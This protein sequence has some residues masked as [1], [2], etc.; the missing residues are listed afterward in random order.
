LFTLVSLLFNGISSGD[1]ILN[2]ELNGQVDPLVE[3]GYSHGVSLNSFF[4]VSFN[5]F[6]QES[7]FL[8]GSE[9][10]G[11]GSSEFVFLHLLEEGFIIEEFTD[12]FETEL[13]GVTLTDFFT[14]VSEDVAKSLEDTRALDHV[15]RSE[16][17]DGV[18][19][20]FWTD[21]VILLVLLF[22]LRFVG[23]RLVGARVTATSEVLRGT[24]LVLINDTL[25]LGGSSG[26]VESL[27]KEVESLLFE[28]HNLLFLSEGLFSLFSLD[29][30]LALAI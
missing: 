28:G 17:E 4:F 13:V 3:L 25:V 9:F 6:L 30:L 14:L 11:L 10:L 18:L 1:N 2:T 7:N 5:V 27:G 26:I 15:V 24:L 12:Q 8:V 21:G 20:L 16:C 22:G 29:T 23:V 19:P